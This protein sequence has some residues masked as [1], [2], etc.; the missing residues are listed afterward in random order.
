MD[1]RDSA[2]SR[3]RGFTLVELV[4]ALSCAAVVLAAAA[5]NIG[6]LYQEWSLWGATRAVETSLRWGRA[7]AVSANS[8]MMFI[9]DEEG[10]FFYWQNPANG[11]RFEGSVRYLTGGVRIVG[12]PRRPLRFTPRGN[13]TPAGTFTLKGDA[14][15]YRVIVS[16]VGRIRVQRD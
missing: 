12:A 8:S 14:G 13:A 1:G 9:V 6:K 15:S 7:H 4:M 2:V 10:R 5:P 16:F 3:S 11:E